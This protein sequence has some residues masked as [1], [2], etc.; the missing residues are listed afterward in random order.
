MKRS[1][2]R[3]RPDRESPLDTAHA[4]LPGDEVEMNSEES[5]PASDPP[6]WTSVS[7][8]GT[9]KPEAAPTHRIPNP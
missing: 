5:F 2:P 9:P 6:S 7:R 8:V 1:A 3:R 4:D